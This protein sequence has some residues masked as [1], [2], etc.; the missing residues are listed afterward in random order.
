M[1][2]TKT[3]NKIEFHQV[4][5]TEILIVESPIDLPIEQKIKLNEVI[6]RPIILWVHNPK[7]EKI[8]TTLVQEKYNPLL[9]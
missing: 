5:F 7:A 6:Q 9:K 1:F 2:T 3:D 8:H 4:P